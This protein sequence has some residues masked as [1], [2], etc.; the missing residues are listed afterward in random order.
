MSSASPRP[1]L[2]PAVLAVVCA[3]GP[4][5]VAPGRPLNRTSTL[6]AVPFALAGSVL[7]LGSLA[8]FASNHTTVNPHAA[9][10][11]STLLTT[12]FNGFSRNPIYLGLASLLVGLGVARRS[13]LGLAGAGLFVAVLDRTQIPYEEAGLQRLFGAEYASY[14]RRVRRWI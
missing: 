12:G 13:P 6:L 4:V 1:L 11:T 10:R 8:Q 9:H 7:C 3:L 5:A 14:R 2:P